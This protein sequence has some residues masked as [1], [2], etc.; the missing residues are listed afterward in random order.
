MTAQLSELREAREKLEAKQDEL[1]A[2]FDEARDG[3]ELNF[4][5]VESIEG[6]PQAVADEVK[7]R[8]EELNELAENV[9][10]LVEA[11][12][13]AEDQKRRERLLEE[14]VQQGP[15]PENGKGAEQRTQKSLG[16]MI[17]ETKRY[18]EYAKRGVPG[19]IDFSFKDVLPSDL[20]AG[21]ALPNTM[22]TK[23][24]FQTSAG[25]APESV[26]IPGLVVD[27]VT[28]PIQLLDIVPLAQ[29]DSAQ[30]VYMEETTRTHAAA[31]TAEG[32]TYPEAEFALTEQTSNVRKIAT[33]IPVTDEQ[34][35]DVAQAES[36]LSGRLIFGLRQR[37]DEQVLTGSGTGVNLEGIANNGS[38]QTQALG[39]DPVPDAF[40][41]AMQNI[42]VTGRAMPTHH[43]IHPDDWEDIRLL[44][45]ADG[46]YIW[47][48]PSEAGPERMFGL[49]V[50][51]ADAGSAGT[52]YVGSFMPAWIS[53]FEKRGVDVQ[54]G[55]VDT[56]FT[57]GERTIRADMRMAFVL[58]RPA[59]FC[60]VTGI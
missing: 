36:Y 11:Q 18:Q 58:F 6:G 44:R 51:Q 19:G 29:T 12:Q 34:L 53:L 49:P 30:I 5:K 13:A 45:T 32:A 50:V 59:A 14:P 24:L 16:Q 42:R 33:S 20:M 39:S 46:I 55:Y 23:T 26:R 43:I 37:L 27:A 40:F 3:E 21:A 48:N 38:I 1:A 17:T 54:V 10:A 35:E 22:G 28:R 15:H 7:R 47:G 4:S 25:W 31:E 41:K 56:Q 8:N 52:G 60:Q 57:E 2:I 9:E